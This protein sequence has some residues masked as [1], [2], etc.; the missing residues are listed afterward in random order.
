MAAKNLFSLNLTVDRN[1]KQEVELSLKANL[2]EDG[3]KLINQFVSSVFSRLS[4][5]DNDD[6]TIDY[7]DDDH[8]TEEDKVK[9]ALNDLE[10]EME[11]MKQE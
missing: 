11:K 1:E 8:K 4:C 9:D 10:Q 2:T 5:R 7:K 6:D 3:E